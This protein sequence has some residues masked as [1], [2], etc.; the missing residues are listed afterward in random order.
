MKPM[1]RGMLLLV[2]LIVPGLLSAQKREGKQD[3]M[4][5]DTIIHGT[6]RLISSQ[7]SFTEGPAVDRKGNVYFTDQPNNKIWK[8]STNGR[9][10]VF[11]DSAGR[12]NGMY[13]DKNGNLVACA[14]E[15]DQLWSIS[16]DKQVKVLVDGFRGARLNGPNDVWITPVGGCYFTD[17]YYQRDYWKRTAPDPAIGG[18]YVY[19]LPPNATTPIVVVND[20]TKPNG[21]IGT[22]DGKRL[23]IADIGAGKTYVYDILPDGKL[24]HKKLF[25]A[26]GSDGMTIDQK[27]NVYITGDGVTIF[28]PQGRQI[29]HI[30]IPQKWTANVCFY[31]KKRNQLFIT[32]S[33]AVYLVKMKV[34]GVR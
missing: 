1:H 3:D 23:Y 34:K 14:D 13:F 28:N 2:L 27:G 10:T 19:Y 6:P 20:I 25:V 15:H 12:A 21:L 24:A 30:P 29:G 4:T 16:S 22:P 17:P 5:A 9:L 33:Q 31:G 7:F 26:K 8:Y 18:Q 32:A 11:M